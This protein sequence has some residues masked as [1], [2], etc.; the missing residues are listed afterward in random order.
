MTNRR[1]FLKTGA[2]VVVTGA[3]AASSVVM[4]ASHNSMATTSPLQG[5]VYTKAQPGMWAKK[6]GGHLP[7]IEVS[8]DSIKIIT[9]HGMSAKHFIVR[10][11]LVLENGTVASAKTFTPE[12]E[13]ESVHKL[14]KGYKGKIF[15]TSFC[16]KH[17]MWMNEAVI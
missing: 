9:D 5:L 8:G 10:H 12:D 7:E 15:A 6:V 4:A 11:T 14:P 3:T 13:A 2:A 17:D 16:N 1:A